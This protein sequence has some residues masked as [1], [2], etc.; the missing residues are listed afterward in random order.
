[1][2]SVDDHSRLEPR[3]HCG[4]VHPGWDQMIRV[5]EICFYTE[6]KKT[7]THSAVQIISWQLQ[8]KPNS[9]EYLVVTF[10]SAE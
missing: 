6:K 8:G 1:M 4:M 3:E 2:E 5:S 10:L 9:K 7:A